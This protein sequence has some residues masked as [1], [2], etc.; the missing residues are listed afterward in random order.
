[1]NPKLIIDVYSRSCRMTV[2]SADDDSFIFQ[3]IDMNDISDIMALYEI[4][5]VPVWRGH[6]RDFDLQRV[7]ENIMEN[8]D[9]EN[10]FFDVLVRESGSSSVDTV[11]YLAWEKH[12]DHTSNHI[13]AHLRMI[14][15]HPDHRRHGLASLM[16]EKF[17]NDAGT[18]GCTKILFDVLS[19]SP[20]NEFYGELGY[21]QWS[22]YMEKHL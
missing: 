5:I 21:R 14:L 20:A 22:N 1:L 16:M 18:N 17:E 19:H 7:R 9:E 13:I 3:K 10:Y 6:G 2:K 8:M 12:R 4:S 15:V 11:G